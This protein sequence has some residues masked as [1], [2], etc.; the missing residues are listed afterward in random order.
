MTP[1]VGV[2]AM[3][4]WFCS[5]LVLGAA[6]A[7]IAADA[8]APPSPE[9]VNAV[10]A[11][12]GNVLAIAQNDPRLDVTL[13]LAD[14]DVTDAVLPEVAKLPSVAS[15]NLA[16]SKITDGGLAAIAGMTTLEKLHLENTGIGDAGL[17]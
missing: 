7:T 12:G 2:P 13:H 8:P 5:L 11:V 15:L 17:A 10:K 6:A 3:R 16:K 1:P 4:F 14:K 9:A